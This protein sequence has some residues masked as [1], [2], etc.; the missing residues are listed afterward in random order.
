MANSKSLP[1]VEEHEVKESLT[2]INK[3]FVELTGPD[4]ILRLKF[5]SDQTSC[6]LL[7]CPMVQRKLFGRLQ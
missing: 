2:I 1:Y 6:R 3:Q 7:T 5:M 4:I